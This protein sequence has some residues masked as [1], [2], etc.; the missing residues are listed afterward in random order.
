MFEREERK[1][2]RGREEV[3]NSRIH[4]HLKKIAEKQP[5]F[6]QVHKSDISELTSPQLKYKEIRKHRLV[7]FVVTLS[8]SPQIRISVNQTM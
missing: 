8:S 3:K 7:P 6:D 5:H 4:Y 1:R 2:I